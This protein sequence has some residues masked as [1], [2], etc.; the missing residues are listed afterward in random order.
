M[1]ELVAIERD[2]GWAVPIAGRK[3][4]RCAIDFAFSLEFWLAGDDRA[5][6]RIETPFTLVV[7]GRTLHIHPER[8]SDLCPALKLF[9]CTVESAFSDRTGVLELKFT[10]GSILR[11]PPHAQLE[12]WQVTL[13]GGAMLV[14]MPGGRVAAYG[15]RSSGSLTPSDRDISIE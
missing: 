13:E 10:N 7:Q 4:T 2:D 6:V 5:L 3:V 14:A 9:D 8:P 11:V 12:S 1:M 15:P